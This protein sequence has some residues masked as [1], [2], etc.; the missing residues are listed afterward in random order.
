MATEVGRWF[1]GLGILFLLIGGVLLLVGRVP[2][3]GQLPGDILVKR[4]HVTVFIPLGTMLLVS[5]VLTILLNLIMRFW[6]R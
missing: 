6:R 5:L 1:I 2:W 3:L 4:E